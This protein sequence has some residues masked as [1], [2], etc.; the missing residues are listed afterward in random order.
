[1]KSKILSFFMTVAL[2]ITI[3]P[4]MVLGANGPCSD[5]YPPAYVGLFSESAS[6]YIFSNFSQDKVEKVNGVTYDKKTNTLTLNNVKMQAYN[7][8]TNVMGDDFKVV[9]KGE[10]Q[11]RAI[12]IWGDGYG[13]NLTVSGNGK[14]II[15]KNKKQKSAISMYA[16]GTKGLLTIE[17]SVNLEAYSQKGAPVIETVSASNGEPAKAIAIKGKTSAKV[18]VKQV[19]EK[20]QIPVS[21][22]A[23]R[24]EDRYQLAKFEKD[25]RYYGGNA[26]YDNMGEET[27]EYQM[28]EMLQDES[29]EEGNIVWVA[30][31]IETQSSIK[32]EKMDIREW[33][34]TVRM[35]NL[36][37]S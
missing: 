26:K 25:D 30:K 11:L 10:N 5:E 17:K 1:M 33:L 34:K 22:K 2:I 13:G 9:V 24:T 12:L 27:G 15:N 35:Q 18:N 19:K 20:Y 16:E 4:Q 6:K 23:Y 37:R 3:M 7:L 14:L 28:Y 36:M 32:P 21:V 29:I 8:V 31:P